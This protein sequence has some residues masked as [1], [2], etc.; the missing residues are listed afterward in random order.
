MLA[1]LPSGNSFKDLIFDLYGDVQ[2][3]IPFFYLKGLSHKA[4]FYQYASS[5]KILFKEFKINFVILLSS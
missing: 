2:P 4:P 1:L 5:G 3:G